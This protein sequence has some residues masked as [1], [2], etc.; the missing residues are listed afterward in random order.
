MRKSGNW[1]APMWRWHH[2]PMSIKGTS[3]VP[4]R[5]H[6]S[7]RRTR[8]ILCVS[9]KFQDDLASEE[10]NWEQFEAKTHELWLIPGGARNV[11]KSGIS[12]GGPPLIGETLQNSFG[13]QRAISREDQLR[14]ET[15]KNLVRHSNAHSKIQLRAASQKRIDQRAFLKSQFVGPKRSENRTGWC[16]SSL[17]NRFQIAKRRFAHYQG[18]GDQIA[19]P[20]VLLRKQGARYANRIKPGKPVDDAHQIPGDGFRG[21]K[22]TAGVFDYTNACL[23]F[24]RGLS[25]PN[26]L[27][28]REITEIE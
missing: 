4:L 24:A 25:I 6:F 14:F 19:K 18:T 22:R 12:S 11:E 5:L 20:L 1:A 7:G 8:P 23:P 10:K 17:P 9:F 26:N 16:L 15:L 28:E 13:R 27:E 21:C 2:W 3:S